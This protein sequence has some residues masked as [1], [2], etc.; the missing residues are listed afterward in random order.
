MR[1]SDCLEGAVRQEIGDEEKIFECAAGIS[2]NCVLMEG[3]TCLQDET[4]ELRVA[5]ML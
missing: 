4:I 1:S 3:A 2:K 5:N